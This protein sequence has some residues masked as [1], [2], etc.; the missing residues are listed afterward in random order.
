MIGKF[1]AASR[2][3]GSISESYCFIRNFCVWD[4]NIWCSPAFLTTTRLEVEIEELEAE[5][6]EGSFEDAELEI[7]WRRVELMRTHISEMKGLKRGTTILNR[8]SQKEK[9]D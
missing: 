3:Y 8:S 6:E 4:T 2:G 1:S 7:R 5:I 9:D